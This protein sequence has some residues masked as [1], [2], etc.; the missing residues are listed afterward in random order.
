MATRKV[1]ILDTDNKIKTTDLGGIGADG[2]KYLRGDKSW[3]APVAGLPS[4]VY[5]DLIS[6]AD[7]TLAANKGGITIGEF[8]IGSGFI[9]ELASGSVFEIS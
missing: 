7:I 1:P 5:S 3:Q 9:L 8:E 2:T 6:S 4:I